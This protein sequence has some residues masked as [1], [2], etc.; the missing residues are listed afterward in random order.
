MT[1]DIVPRTTTTFYILSFFWMWDKF[2]YTFLYTN[3]LNMSNS[4]C[5]IQSNQDLL[6]EV[7]T[8]GELC[9][10][11]C[12][13]STPPPISPKMYVLQCTTNFG[14]V[15]STRRVNMF[16]FN[17]FSFSVDPISALFGEQQLY[18]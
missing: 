15:G 1:C 17:Q 4:N 3:V 8:L 12:L 10:L 16:S 11:T 6:I 14:G 9:S 18:I 5:T 2:P 7:D 13:A